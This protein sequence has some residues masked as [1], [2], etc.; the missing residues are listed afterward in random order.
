ML[1][2]GFAITGLCL[3]ALSTNAD[4]QGVGKR[5]PGYECMM[6][7][8]TEQQAMDPNFH[9][10]VKVQPSA[11]SQTIGWQPGIVIVKEPAVPKNGYL[12]IVRANGQK[13]WI[14]ASIVKPY[15]A[16]ADPT[17]KCAPEIL[18]NGLIGSGP[19]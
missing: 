18:P 11:S 15:R 8:I 2:R 6:L 7:N 3:V 5:L 19:G 1:T 12:Q 4:A 13:A 9:V 10:G 17:A 16:E 14:K